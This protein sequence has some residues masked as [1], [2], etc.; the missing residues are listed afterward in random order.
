MMN[1]LKITICTLILA[2]T[3]I[4]ALAQ[5]S[6]SNDLF[7]YEMEN[8][9]SYQGKA[10]K[11]GVFLTAITNVDETSEILGS[12]STAW[13]HYL[14]NEPQEP[15]QQF[16]VD[17]KNGYL[18]YTFDTNLC[19]DFDDVDSQTIVEMCYWNCADGKH[20]LIA[21][22]IVS[23]MDGKYHLGQYSGIMFYLYDN[24]SHRLWTA[25]DEILG[26]YVEPAIDEANCKT[27]DVM[28]LW[29]ET[30]AVYSLPQQGKDID[31]VVYKGNKK[32]ATHLVWDGMRFEQK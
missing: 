5:Q 7:I 3:G 23:M 14:H 17:E 18:R 2:L 22:N 28:T 8:R 4:S 20:K 26:A 19:D 6:Y 32:N 27:G 21:E 15:C 11:I 31:V 10:P 24:D 29:D 9:V 1:N 25:D 13:E 30:V 12:L 16:I